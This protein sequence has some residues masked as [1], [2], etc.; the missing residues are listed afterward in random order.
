M[1]NEERLNAIC[2]PIL[3]CKESQLLASLAQCTRAPGSGRQGRESCI[4]VCV[5]P[6]RVS[7][8]PEGYAMQC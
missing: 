3:S 7:D 5:C 8:I 2:L 4:T 6:N 1:V